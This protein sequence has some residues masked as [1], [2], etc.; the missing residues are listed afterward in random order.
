MQIISKSGKRHTAYPCKNG[1]GRLSLKKGSRCVE[2]YKKELKKQSEFK[3]ENTRKRSPSDNPEYRRN[4]Y[5]GKKY[6]CKACGKPVWRHGDFCKE[7]YNIALLAAGEKRQVEV[8]NRKVDSEA[9]FKKNYKPAKKQICPKSP[10]PDKNHVEIIDSVKNIGKCKY[11]GRIKDY[12]KLQK[13]FKEKAFG[14]A[15]YDNK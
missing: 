2:C 11:C 5:Q 7:C 10:E 4:H 1:C 14:R 15:E 9:R 3:K 6:P 8:N 13:E 12:N